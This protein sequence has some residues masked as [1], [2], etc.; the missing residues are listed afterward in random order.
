MD[1]NETPGLSDALLQACEAL[2]GWLPFDVFMREVLTHPAEGYYSRASA[3]SSPMGIRGDFVTAPSMGPW[4]AIALAREF[5]S[6]ARRV[7]PGTRLSIRE[8]GAG[9]GQLAAD[10]LLE[11]H[12]SNCLPLAY[13]IV[14]TSPALV[15]LQKA[16]TYQCLALRGLAG[17][18]DR[19]IW[20]SDEGAQT[21]RPL[22][23]LVLA[24]EVADALPVK[25]FEW[26][27]AQA[28]PLEW[29]LRHQ[30][31]RWVWSSREAGPELADRV[32]ARQDE[33]SALL[34]PW[35]QGHR[36]EWSPMLSPWARGLA[37]GL[38]WGEVVVLDYGYERAE[39]DHPDRSHGTLAAHRAHRRI[40]DPD[41][42][43]EGPGEQDLTA[44][45]DFSELVSAFEGAGCA[46]QSLKTQAAWLL[47]HHILDEAQSRLFPDPESRGRAPSDPA[48]VSALSGLQ[49]L[50]SDAA[51][52]QQF[53]VL[54]VSRFDSE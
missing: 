36:G 9:T 18:S 42:L 5:E 25:V 53:L 16:H 26:R 45:V 21:D 10:I 41:A 14:E 50:L 7:T 46:L 2:G 8:F 43:L 33:V 4:L 23:G 29:G 39:L 52:G 12:G 40:D 6:L 3:E 1:K 22:R 51:M 35:R 49:T 13:E 11:L 20:S 48:K 24:N 44:H 17:L 28:Q 38:A 34:W 15:S 54:T 31:E 32:K 19:L 47:D 30:S 37:H 27:G